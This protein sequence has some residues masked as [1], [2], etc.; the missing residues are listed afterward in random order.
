MRAGQCKGRADAQMND[1]QMD[2]GME[3]AEPRRFDPMAPLIVTDICWIMDEMVALEV[4]LFLGS[5]V[6]G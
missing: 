1:P 5:L 4:S 2:T 6:S 3:V